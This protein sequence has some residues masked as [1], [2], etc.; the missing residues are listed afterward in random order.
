VVTQATYAIG[1]AGSVTLDRAGGQL[2]IVSAVPSSG[3][4]VAKAESEG[5]LAIK[6][7]LRSSTTQVE[8]RGDTL[9]RLAAELPKGQYA[10]WSNR[11]D[12][13][14]AMLTRAVDL[15]GL[16]KATLTFET[17][18]EIENDYDY[19]FITVSTDGGKSWDTLPGSLTTT[20]DPQGVNYGHGITGISGRP[21]AKLEDGH[22]GRWVSEQ[23]DLSPYASQQILL[24]FWQIT[25]QGFNAPGMLIDNIAIPELG[26][27][28]NVEEGAGDWQA[29][30]FV[31]VDGTL[32]QQWDLRLVITGA[33][34]A[35]RV[36]PLSADGSG[37]AVGQLA[38]DEQAVLVVLG[39]TLHTTE[40]ANYSVS[41]N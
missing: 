34:G 19:A 16:T 4:T 18:Y 33:D 6:V 26:F 12:D 13:S 39:A 11:S 37:R 23:M 40:P 24:R 1:S 31:R 21:G 15:R 35:T 8:F 29:E 36:V 30:G 2:Q 10:W 22:R 7:T 5:P 38:A 20:D 9:V 14:Q 32:S 41:T 3:W 25:D 28:D 17:W 27:S